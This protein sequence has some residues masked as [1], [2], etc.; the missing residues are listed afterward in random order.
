[1]GNKK[2]GLISATF[3]GISS[4]I[5]SGWLF[6]AYK[7][8]EISGPAA[9]I[10]WIVGAVIIILLALCFSEIASLY[11][12][13]GLSAVVA[14][15]SHNKN[16][17]FPFAIAN[18][19]GIVAVI[20][21]EA[22]ATI[23]YL[24]NLFP[25][26]KPYLFENESLTLMGNGISALLVVMFCLIN[27]W[28]VQIMAKT[29]NILAVIKTFIPVITALAILTV[30]F[31]T[32]NF[33]AVNNSFVPYGVGSI[34]TAIITCG[35]II[36]FNGFQTVISF[37]SELKKPHI[38][39]PLSIIISVTFC[40]IVYL[41]LQV[42]YIGAMPE[43]YVKKGWSNIVMNAPM[44]QLSASLGLGF[45]STIIYFGAF[46]APSG[47]AIAFTGTA[48]RMFTAMAD[49]E[50]MPKFF[51]YI[52]PKVGLSRRSL[53]MNS[54]LAIVFILCF[55]NWSNLAIVLSLFH[56]LSYMPIPLALLIFRKYVT[57]DK[58]KFRFKG[59]VIISLLLF[60]V[61]NFLI[62]YGSGPVLIQ[63]I[64]ILMVFQIIFILSGSGSVSLLLKGIGES[65]PVFIYF[66]LLA[67]LTKLS[68][69]N[70]GIIKGYWFYVIGIVFSIIM[71]YFLIF[72]QKKDGSLADVNIEKYMGMEGH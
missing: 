32:S 66:I 72:F 36:S 5:G 12:I 38:N 58:Y 14:T 64:I 11:P 19:L 61:F 39:I 51:A 33:M 17:G 44:V 71:F 68:P 55:K 40:L 7:T 62:M 43:E 41:L 34:F 49:N 65:L 30:S 56:V 37:A 31:K 25:H 63:L 4:I 28:G 18:W 6:A 46:V 3:L 35:I 2:I 60:I 48:S 26:F 67:I 53:V 57:T 29:N 9:I 16:F 22:D 13:R 52:N 20:A 15:I 21:L 47:T 69:E 45:L 70:I 27:Y 24:I 10:S 23:E 42:A 1:M 54:T 59:G 8:A 50:Q